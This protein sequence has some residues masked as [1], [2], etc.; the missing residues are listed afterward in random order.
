MAAAN[1]RIRRIKS[2]C[3]V[4]IKLHTNYTRVLYTVIECT[5]EHVA[6]FT[7]LHRRLH[8]NAAAVAVAVVCGESVARH[9]RLRVIDQ[10]SEVTYLSNRF[11]SL[12]SDRS[13]N[14]IDLRAA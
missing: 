6:G 2:T 14:N 4:R 5:N 3:Y 11:H 10:S 13:L 8:S 12:V 7:L 9:T 1:A